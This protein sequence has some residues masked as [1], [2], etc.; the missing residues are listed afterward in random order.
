MSQMEYKREFRGLLIEYSPIYD[1]EFA[2]YGWGAP[3]SENY[4]ENFTLQI[5]IRKL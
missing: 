2:I 1:L 5:T 3:A 4:A